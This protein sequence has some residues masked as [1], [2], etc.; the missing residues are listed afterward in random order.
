[1]HITAAHTHTH[2]VTVSQVCLKYAIANNMKGTRRKWKAAWPSMRTRSASLSTVSVEMMTR[3]G[4]RKVQ[5][6]SA[7]YHSGWMKMNVN[8]ANI[9]HVHAHIQTQTHT[10]FK[11]DYVANNNHPYSLLWTR[12]PDVPSFPPFLPSF[13][14]F[15]HSLLVKKTVFLINIYFS[16]F[17]SMT[18]LMF[19]WVSMSMWVLVQNHTHTGNW[20][21]M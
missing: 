1:M 3:I 16:L 20:E 10:H 12:S 21:N 11:P 5:I 14:L 2:R 4:K 13:S 18:V 19:M 15:C 17:W 9:A 6:G 8:Y 7:K